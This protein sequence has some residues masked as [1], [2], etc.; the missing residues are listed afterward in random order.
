MLSLSEVPPFP[1]IPAP[2]YLL[3]LL[4]SFSFFLIL[5]NFNRIPFLF[6]GTLFYLS[7]ILMSVLSFVSF[8]CHPVCPFLLVLV[9]LSA[10]KAFVN[11]KTAILVC[12]DALAGLAGDQVCC[13][14][15]GWAT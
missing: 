8:H 12:L 9:S 14:V 15:P 1:P 5:F 3:P 4:S 13:G 2:S 10:S 6:Q 7:E 11:L